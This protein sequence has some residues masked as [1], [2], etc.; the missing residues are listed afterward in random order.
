M[1][2]PGREWKLLSFAVPSCRFRLCTHECEFLY[3]VRPLG[4]P[5]AA[6]RLVQVVDTFGGLH[7]CDTVRGAAI[8]AELLCEQLDTL[9]HPDRCEFCCDGCGLDPLAA[10]N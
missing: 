10:S 5:A 2:G 4:I 1:F 6:R 8:P 7:T 9:L 3:A